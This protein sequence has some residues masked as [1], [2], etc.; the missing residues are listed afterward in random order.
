MRAK[1]GVGNAM[2]RGEIGP[3]VG[4]RELKS[5]NYVQRK[6]YLVTP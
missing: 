1:L 6:H 3:L 5:V 4:H 2:A